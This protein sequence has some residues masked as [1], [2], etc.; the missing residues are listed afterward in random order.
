MKK[1]FFSSLFVNL[2]VMFLFFVTGIVSARYLGPA[3]KGELAVVSRWPGLFAIIFTLGLPG[4]LVY[5]GKKNPSNSKSYLAAY[6]VLGAFLSLVAMGLGWFLLPLM[7]SNQSDT[8]INLSR[9]ALITIIINILVDGSLSTLQSHNSFKK[10]M[11]LRFIIPFGTLVVILVLIFLKNYTVSTFVIT[12]T[13]WSFVVLLLSIILISNLCLPSFGKIIKSSKE[14]LT[15]S[16]STFF[17]YLATNL[18]GTL[19]QVVI[20]LFLT[21]YQLGFY[22]VAISIGGVVPSFLVGAINL[23]LWPKLMDL[24]DKE[25]IRKVED[26]HSLIFYSSSVIS[27]LILIITPIILPILYGESYRN[28]ILMSEIM[29]LCVPF[30]V[31]YSVFVNFLSSLGKFKYITYAEILG[32]G[33]GIISTIFLVQVAGGV[34]AAIGSLITILVKWIFS[35]IVGIKLDLKF[36]RLLTI[37]LKMY[38]ELLKKIFIKRKKT[39]DSSQLS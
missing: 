20:S 33:L 32:L 19:D 28:A 36:S 14:L 23:F 12:N 26:M 1:L 18:G 17:P 29:L 13:I 7:L 22:T 4:A 25:R 5:L 16:I 31:A 34:G 24:S 6:I 2:L 3:G 38:F 10:L 9:F 37:N 15:K 27:L 35:I 39:I 21:A 30:K 11:L 8:V